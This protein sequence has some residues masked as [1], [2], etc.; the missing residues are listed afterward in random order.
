MPQLDR[1]DPFIA[2]LVVTRL[3]GW[4]GDA[5]AVSEIVENDP[6]NP[7]AHAALITSAKAITKRWPE[8]KPHQGKAYL[9]ALLQRV[10]V[11]PGRIVI[12]IDGERAMATL[13]A[14]GSCAPSPSGTGWSETL[15]SP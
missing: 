8:L 3:K 14:G 7:S 12:E 5:A 9:N 11:E 15:I 13:L 6:L 1:G 2:E 4:L 10:I